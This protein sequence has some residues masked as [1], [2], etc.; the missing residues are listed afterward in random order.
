MGFI[1]RQQ[2]WPYVHCSIAKQ[3][4]QAGAVREQVRRKTLCSN[5]FEYDVICLKHFEVDSTWQGWMKALSQTFANSNTTWYHWISDVIP[6]NLQ[7]PTV[8]TSIIPVQ[9]HANLQRPTVLTSIIPVQ[10]HAKCTE[11]HRMGQQTVL[12]TV[13]GAQYTEA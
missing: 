8:L 1:Q 7:R 9:Q 10:Q 2:C 13:L 4:K 5:T 3:R 12:L 11:E 6:Q